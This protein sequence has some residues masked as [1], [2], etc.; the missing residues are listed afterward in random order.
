MLSPWELLP[1]PPCVRSCRELATGVRRDLAPLEEVRQRTAMEVM[2]WFVD[3]VM[4]VALTADERFS[5]L[6]LKPDYGWRATASPGRCTN[7]GQG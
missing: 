5:M 7:T 6:L 3:P 4:C 1:P 2:R